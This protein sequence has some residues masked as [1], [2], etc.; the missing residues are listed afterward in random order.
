M[1]V[2]TGETYWRA[3]GAEPVTAFPLTANIATEV[4]IVGAG[5]TGVL[6]AHYLVTEGVDVALIDKAEVGVGS[7]AASTGLL[8]HEVDTP[9][10]ELIPKV[11]E[12]NAVHAYKRGL[13]A[14]KELEQLATDH[15]THCG[16]SSQE[17][18]YFASKSWHYAQLKREHDCRKKYGFD[19]QLLAEDELK[20]ITVV[21][22]SSALLSRGNAQIDPY[23]FTQH[24]V[25][26]SIAKGLRVFANCEATYISETDDSVVVITPGGSI[27]AKKIVY[28]TGYESGKYL[29]NEMGDLNSTYVVASEPIGN[30][31]LSKLDCLF[32][33]TA[34]PY[35]YARQTPDNRVIIGGEDTSFSNDH[36][37]NRLFKKQIE[38]LIVRFRELFPAIDFIPSYAWAG[39]FAETKDGLAYIGEVS[40]RPR[41]YFA[42]GYGG[43]GI[44]FSVIAA[45]L[46]ADLYL[47]R[48]NPDEEVFRFNR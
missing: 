8:Q 17:A 29:K 47:G 2:R 7:T 33:E 10:V 5:I 45:R 11:G 27:T 4:V 12:K 41:A 48:Q 6:I 22:A 23:A 38:K 42:L 32:W 31:R 14:I 44:T 26:Q 39:T 18:I 13:T 19:V 3:I 24:L 25:S 37:S 16:F 46:I 15:P 43:N 40:D 28:A 30:S 34:R 35:F 9:L 36:Q 20:E 21:N 1:K